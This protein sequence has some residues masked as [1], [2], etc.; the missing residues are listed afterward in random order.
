MIAY[1]HVGDHLGS[2]PIAHPGDAERSKEYFAKCVSIA[3]GIVQTDP[4][5]RTARYDLANSLLRWGNISLPGVASLGALRE[6]V[7]IL[8]SLVEENPQ[9]IRYR[10]PLTL[11]YQYTGL[12]LR[13]MGRAEE[14]LGE[15]GRS[16]ALANA[17]MTAHPGDINFLIRIA[18]GERLIAEILVSRH[19][20]AA[21]LTHAER[22]LSIAEKYAAGPEAGLRK[23]FLADAHLG[24]AEVQRALGKWPEARDHARQAD[25][26]WSSPEVKDVDP[27]L[28]Q[29]AA[30]ILTE[31][32][33]RMARK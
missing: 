15:L 22:G 10:T 4:Q 11:A 23:K 27:K 1:G 9:A 6:S 19:D 32:T 20:T 8:E 18:R 7:A 16:V 29:Q 17:M 25:S 2:P 5:D 28:R 24:V 33:V 31:S 12:C 14:A 26:L 3:R 30:A 21:A 13:D